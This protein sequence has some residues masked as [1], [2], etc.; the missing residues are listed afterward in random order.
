[1]SI[2]K[3]SDGFTVLYTILVLIIVGIVGFTGWYVW[4]T[5]TEANENF[6]SGVNASSVAHST[7]YKTKKVVDP[8]ANWQSYSSAVGN[9]TFK[10]PANWT[11]KEQ[12]INSSLA[13]YQKQE[14]NFSVNIKRPEAQGY[15]IFNLIVYA[16][17]PSM[18]NLPQDLTMVTTEDLPNG[19]MISQSKK[20]D[21]S[22]PYT[23]TLSIIGKQGIAHYYGYPLI[24]KYYL[25]GTG[26]FGMDERTS[27]NLT[28]EEQ[29]GS[30]EWKDAKLLLQSIK[31]N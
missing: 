13:K 7:P 29:V 12:S 1:M 23:P 30:I 19:I 24:N 28:Y 9:F 4:N 27:T 10:Y 16:A 21:E 26:G 17:N 8:Y 11:L 31:F 3:D 5:N 18:E 22:S 20:P 25:S 14:L 2:S 15:F 6:K